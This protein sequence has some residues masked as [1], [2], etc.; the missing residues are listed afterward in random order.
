[1]KQIPEEALTYKQETRQKRFKITKR[2]NGSI[3]MQTLNDKPSVT[4]QSFTD[5]CDVNKILK[6]FMKT[7]QQLPPITGQYA[8]VSEV[9]NLDTA[10]SQLNQAQSLFDALP[11]EI[12]RRF[13]NSPVELV[14]F[15]QNPLNREEGEKLGLLK[16][17][18][19]TASTEAAET[20]GR[21]NPKSKSKP[22]VNDDE[23]N[24]DDKS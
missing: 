21:Q 15:L 8:D 7:G 4:D 2:K 20:A 5:D 12:R 1:M 16:P 13:G 18:P 3:R 14:N 9:P 10:L 17:Q 19:R 23:L 11:A 22:K 24:D 6:R